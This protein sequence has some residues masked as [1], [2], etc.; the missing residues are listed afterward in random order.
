ML[1]FSPSRVNGTVLQDLKA[2]G[3]STWRRELFLQKEPNEQ[4]LK[5]S[6]HSKCWKYCTDLKTIQPW[7]NTNLPINMLIFCGLENEGTLSIIHIPYQ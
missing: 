6:L 4:N 7:K 1:A 3:G 2:V 5:V